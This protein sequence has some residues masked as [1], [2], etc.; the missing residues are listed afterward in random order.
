MFGIEFGIG[1]RRKA[2]EVDPP[3][4]PP[5]D[6]T[7]EVNLSLEALGALGLIED[8]DQK[9]EELTAA[10][11]LLKALD[12]KGELFPDIQ[13]SARGLTTSEFLARLIELNII[14]PTGIRRNLWIPEL[15]ATG[16]YHGY[17]YETINRTRLHEA[18]RRKA[19][20]SVG[21]LALHNAS[22]G[23]SGID[24]LLH[25][26]GQL[27]D[28][29]ELGSL[30]PSQKQMLNNFVRTAHEQ[31]PQYNAGGLTMVGVSLVALQRVILGVSLPFKNDEFIYFA[32]AGV[33]GPNN[34]P[35]WHEGI[36][37]A[38]LHEGRLAF[39]AAHGETDARNKRRG[40]IGLTIGVAARIDTAEN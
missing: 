11:R 7:E 38:G 34:N 25:N 20:A 4:E 36:G 13:L 18:T 23:F 33:V 2:A 17:S 15:A 21:H 35:T 24:P 32:Q 16:E 6:V 3:T 37:A 27:H 28:E 9:A 10:Y 1:R 26:F 12:K 14:S 40:G 5:I 39:G 29:E 8:R 22:A 19:P 30:R 31:H